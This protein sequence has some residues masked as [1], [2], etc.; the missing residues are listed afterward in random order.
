ALART[1][2][3]S[4]PTDRST[5][6]GGGILKPG[7]PRRKVVAGLSIR[8]DFDAFIRDLATQVLKNGLPVFTGC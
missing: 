8:Q 7:R 5:G 1:S 3:P 6:G 2:T 4:C